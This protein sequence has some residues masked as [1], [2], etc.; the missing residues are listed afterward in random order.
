MSLNPGIGRPG[1]DR[2]IDFLS[3]EMGAKVIAETGD[4]PAFVRW[5]NQKWPLGRYLRRELRKAVGFDDLGTPERV[6]ASVAGERAARLELDLDYFEKIRIQDGYNAQARQSRL[7][8]S[9]KL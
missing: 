7:R 1:L 6:L 8:L 2:L 3:S 4:V 5:N 9:E